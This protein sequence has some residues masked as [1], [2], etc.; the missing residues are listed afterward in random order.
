M[1]NNILSLTILRRSIFLLII[2]ISF[3]LQFLIIPRTAL[4]FP[5]YLLIPVTASVSMHEKEPAGLLWGAIAGI[6]WDTASPVTDG[7]F[8]LI[9]AVAFLITGLLT[10][11]IMRNTLLTAILFTAVYSLIP[12]LLQ[13]VYFHEG[14]TAEIFAAMLTDSIIPAVITSVM[15]CLPVYPVISSISKHFRRERQ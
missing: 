10:R 11:Y 4:A 15:L 12:V 13:A 2:F 9:F 3:I 6:L 14:L 8:A 5:V 7:A 1:K